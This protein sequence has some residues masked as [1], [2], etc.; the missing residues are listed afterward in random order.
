VRTQQIVLAARPEGTPRESD[1]RLVE[2]ELP[3]LED[4][5]VLVRVHYLSLDPYMRR[6][7]DATPSYAPSVELDHVIVGGT[8]GEVVESKH[9]GYSAG[10]FVVAS[11]GWQTHA[12]SDGTAMIK[13]DPGIVPLTAYLGVVG[14]PG[15]TAHDG[16][17]ELAN[18]RAGETVVVRRG[19]P[20]PTPA[21]ASA[22]PSPAARA[23]ARERSRAAS[24]ARS[25]SRRGSFVCCV[26]GVASATACAQAKYAIDCDGK[27]AT[28]ATDAGSAD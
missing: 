26:D 15:V 8:V 17:F 11:L 19:P 23:R 22:A 21:T 5:Q 2:T 4:G 6:R 20:I 3:P 10:D 28:A 25:R 13:V 16:L 7:L 24:A 9:A 27:P 1:F 12:I 14:M 18:P